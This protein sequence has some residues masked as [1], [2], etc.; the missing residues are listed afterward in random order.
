VEL[1][2]CTVE[3]LVS[4]VATHYQ[5]PPEQAAE[6]VA[7]FVQHLGDLDLVSVEA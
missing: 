6:D 7:R 3:E 5:I 4:L 1:P 2:Q